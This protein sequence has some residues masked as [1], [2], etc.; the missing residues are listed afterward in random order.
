VKPSA[1]K[2]SSNVTDTNCGTCAATSPA[3][4]LF[5]RATARRSVPR[6]S[7]ASAAVQPDPMNEESA[8]SAAKN[9]DRTTREFIDH[10]L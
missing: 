9:D 4:G 1:L 7:V 2:L 5:E 10:G 8:A 3:G 6:S